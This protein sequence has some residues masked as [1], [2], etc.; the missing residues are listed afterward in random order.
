MS[1]T[2]AALGGLVAL[3][4][5]SGISPAR[6]RDAATAEGQAMEDE[7]RAVIASWFERQFNQR[8]T[9]AF[10]DLY[11]PDFIEHSPLAANDDT[12]QLRQMIDAGMAAMPHMHAQVLRLVAQDDIVVLHMLFQSS[13]ETRGVVF[14]HF[15]RLRDGLIVEHWDVAQEVPTTSPNPRPMY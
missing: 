9:S 8:D 13:P 7:N 10:I 5:I 14:A 1:L 6:A 15:F 12:A 4:L 11:A 2:R 3:I